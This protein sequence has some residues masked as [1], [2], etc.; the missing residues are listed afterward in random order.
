MN[1]S[2]R[3]ILVPLD[4]TPS[5][6]YALQH[7]IKIAKVMNLSISLLHIISTQKEEAASVAR[8]NEISEA[9]QRNHEINVSKIIMIGNIYTT[10]SDLASQADCA[11]V[12]MKTDGITGSQKYTGSRAMKIITGSKS[13]FIVV[14]QPPLKDIFVDI[15][16]PIDYRVENKE[17]LSYILNYSKFYDFK[18]HLIKIHTTD[19]IFL[20]NVTNNLNYAKSML[21]S[22]GLNYQIHIGIGKLDY[23]SEINEY[24]NSVN[25]DLIITQLQRNLTLSKFIFGVKEQKILVNPYKIP[26]MCVNP[27]D[28]WVFAGFR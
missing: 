11:L 14:Q 24:A 26:V 5:S 23:A 13:P 18:L 2:P 1:M 3:Y 28:M 4:F 9:T 8:L 20:K 19:R 15:V 10:I 6:D 27:K 16:Y 22:K 17:I 21:E 7:A 25:A 12:V